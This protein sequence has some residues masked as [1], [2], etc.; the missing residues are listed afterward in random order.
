M[1]VGLKDR[2]NADALIDILKGADTD[3]DGTINYT[4]FLAAT[5]NAQTFM[6]ESYLKAAFKL[7]DKDGSGKIDGNEIR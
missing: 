6:K 1:H 3:N 5:M 7:F 4:E 2:E